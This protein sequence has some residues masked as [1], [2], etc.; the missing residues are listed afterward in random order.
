MDRARKGL[1]GLVVL[2]LGQFQIKLF[3]FVPVRRAADIDKGRE[4][5]ACIVAHIFVNRFFCRLY[6]EIADTSVDGSHIFEASNEGT[7]I[8]KSGAS[9]YL[10]DRVLQESIIKILKILARFLNR[11]NF[12][13]FSDHISASLADLLFFVFG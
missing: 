5:V 7:Y 3:K 9:H 4:I 1:L 8:L 11:R 6:K 10:R 2:H 12:S 13:E